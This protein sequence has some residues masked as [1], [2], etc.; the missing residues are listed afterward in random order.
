MIRI[1][2][3]GKI[4]LYSTVSEMGQGAKTGQAQV[5]ADE[6]DAPWE[7]ISVELGPF[8]PTGPFAFMGTGGSSSIRRHWKELRQAGATVRAQLIAAA[9]KRWNCAEGDC[10]AEMG[11][12]KHVSNGQALDYGALAADAANCAAPANPPLKPIEARRYIGKPLATLENGD[13]SRGRAI[14]GIDVRPQGLLFASIRAAPVYGAKLQSV[15][16]APVE[17]IPGVKLVV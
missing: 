1:A 6:L 13:K 15:D 5:L 12:I 17:G 16:Q 7:A 2:A 3:D 4:T 11:S 14:Y 10:R 9:A 8:S